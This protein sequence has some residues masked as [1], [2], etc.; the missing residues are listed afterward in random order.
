MPQ[1]AK[2]YFRNFQA[3]K[4][5]K[6]D[7]D[8]QTFE[9]R[10]IKY[11]CPRCVKSQAKYLRYMFNSWTRYHKMSTIML[12]LFKSK[13][14]DD[15]ILCIK[16]TKLRK[17][18]SP[19]VSLSSK[20]IYRF[21]LRKDD[22]TF[23]EITGY[24]T[25]AHFLSVKLTWLLG[26]LILPQP[27]PDLYGG[28][29]GRSTWNILSQLDSMLWTR[30]TYIYKM[31]VS[32]YFPS[33]PL[34]RLAGLLRRY[35]SR[36][37][38]NIIIRLHKI[39]GNSGLAQ[40]N[41][42][43]PLLANFYMQHVIGRSERGGF[44][45]MD[46]ILLHNTTAVGLTETK[47][48]W[49]S[50]IKQWGLTVKEEKCSSIEYVGGLLSGPLEYLGLR[51]DQ[52]KWR[53]N[54]S[55]VSP[56][57][58]LMANGKEFKTILSQRSPSSPK[59]KSRRNNLRL[60]GQRFSIVNCLHERY[61][62]FDIKNNIVGIPRIRLNKGH[63]GPDLTIEHVPEVLTRVMELRPHM[64]NREKLHILNL[65]RR[66]KTF[67]KPLAADTNYAHKSRRAPTPSQWRRTLNT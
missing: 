49:L 35:M 31:D 17:E 63:Y 36:R 3:Q 65:I 7:I 61:P 53:R 60:M 54:D 58:S 11:K 27:H 12:L 59:R 14:F 16:G 47:E 30:D 6:W 25:S 32:N 1:L 13:A 29:P 64:P 9:N 39:T 24:K 2:L 18:R 15:F 21:L 67:K 42:T 5:S 46:D 45:F 55:E 26:N 40:G 20:S 8:L 66:F 52:G 38:C 23:R 4:N 56:L 10:M 50:N 41:S 19:N 51:L 44:V 48:R 22:G 37:L 57:G 33:I 43:S 62:F 28:I 34:N